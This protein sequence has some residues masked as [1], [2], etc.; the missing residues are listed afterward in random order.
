MPKERLTLA[1]SDAS[2]ARGCRRRQRRSELV[3]LQTCPRTGAVVRK[4]LSEANVALEEGQDIEAV[5][6]GARPSDDNPLRR[7][8]AHI[9]GR[10]GDEL[11]TEGRQ[12]RVW[13][14][15]PLVADDRW[16]HPKSVVSRGVAVA[17][18]QR[19]GPRD[20]RFGS[21]E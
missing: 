1:A 11:M 3:G 21:N 9:N 13:I 5:L 14:A 18:L 7:D 6:T 15:K 17:A 10:F 12:A 4:Q 2:A 19:H 8:A 16:Q 20:R